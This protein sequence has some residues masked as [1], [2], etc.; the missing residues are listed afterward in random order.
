[1]TSLSKDEEDMD[2]ETRNNFDDAGAIKQDAFGG[3]EKGIGTIDKAARKK[4]ETRCGGGSGRRLQS[5][6]KLEG[7]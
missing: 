4:D 1:V 3:R 6:K 7:V 2:G 5:G